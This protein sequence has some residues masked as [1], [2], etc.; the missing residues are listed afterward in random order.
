MRTAAH[1]HGLGIK[2]IQRFLETSGVALLGLGKGLEPIRDFVE[3]L[4]SRCPG[5]TRVHVCVFVGLASNG[6]L[7]IV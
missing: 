3:P 4:V 6:G 2:R 5:H 1:Y 7:E